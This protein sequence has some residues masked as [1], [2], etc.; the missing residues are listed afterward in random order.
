M[1][2]DSPPSSTQ[3]LSHSDTFRFSCHGSLSCFNT[4]CRNK[5]LPLTPYDVL[6]LR[7]AL[8]L[9]SENFLSEYTL[10]SKDPQTGFPVVSIKMKDNPERSCPFVSPEG[11]TVYG[12][13]PTACRL[14]PLARAVSAGLGVESRKEFCYLL[15]LPG[16]LGT[17]EEEI[18]TIDQW[19]DDQELRTYLATNDRVVEFV[20][21]VKRVLGRPLDERGLRKV[22][23]AL[24]NLDVFREFVVSTNFLDAL[25]IEEEMRRRVHDDD[26]ALLELGLVYLRHALASLCGSR[27]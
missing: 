26:L 1:F 11:C 22:L 2:M 23:A 15:D 17:K 14:F 3:R 19:M 6:K 5:H 21:M 8:D 18:R 20:L 13:R 4:C 25:E 12:D 24:Y 9:D 10:Y 16:C 7:A 27:K